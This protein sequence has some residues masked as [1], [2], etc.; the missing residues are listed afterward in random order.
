MKRIVLS[1]RLK[2]SIEFADLISSGKLFQSSGAATEKAT[3]KA[4]GSFLLHSQEAFPM[5]NKQTKYDSLQM[6]CVMSV[7]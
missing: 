3:E 4:R 5:M 1:L 2:S 6:H 7:K